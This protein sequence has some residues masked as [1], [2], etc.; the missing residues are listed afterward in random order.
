MDEG[1]RRRTVSVMAGPTPVVDRMD[2]GP[3]T[4]GV[5]HTS[6]WPEHPRSP[7]GFRSDSV[8][9]EATAG[10]KV[11]LKRD[12]PTKDSRDEDV[13]VEEGMDEE[14]WEEVREAPES[15]KA[16]EGLDRQTLDGGHETEGVHVDE[17]ERRVQGAGKDGD[18]PAD[19]NESKEEEEKHE[20]EGVGQADD[21]VGTEGSGGVADKENH[22]EGE[23]EGNICRICFGGNDEELGEHLLSSET[24]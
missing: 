3:G 21:R 14:Q 9:E 10:H 12:S 20:G 11:E 18:G 4:D 23:S 6:E 22:E 15:D 24:S 2:D 7:G 17:V 13:K 5:P 1:L 19:L 16:W 8:S